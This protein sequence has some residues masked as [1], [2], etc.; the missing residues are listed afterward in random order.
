MRMTP[1]RANTLPPIVG[2]G[3]NQPVYA[4]AM[5]GS[6]SMMRPNPSPK[7]STLALLNESIHAD[8]KS[9]TAILDASIKDLEAQIDNLR[10][11]EQEFI[12]LGLEDSRKMLGA[13]VQE[14]EDKIRQKRREKGVILI[15]KLKREGYGGLAAQ[16]GKEVGVEGLGMGMRGL[17]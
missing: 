7:I 6:G 5:N 15:E 3:V 11:Y 2:M 16:V 12:D 17:G 14:L 9:P 4:S 1:D 10:K 8:T 13:Q